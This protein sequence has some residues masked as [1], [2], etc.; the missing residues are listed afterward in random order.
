MK[1]AICS[2]ILIKNTIVKP[3]LFSILILI[4]NSALAQHQFGKITQDEMNMDQ[5]AFD[6]EADAVVIFDIGQSLFVN[7][8]GGLDIQFSRTRRVKIFNKDG[9][10]WGEVSIPFYMD[11][12]GK[13]E[14]V[15]SI[16]GFVY[17]VENNILVITELDPK[18][19][20]TEKVNDKWNRKKFAFP[21][22]KEGTI[23][24]YKYTMTTPFMFNLP[25]WEFQDKIPV[26]Y[27][28]YE[29]RMVPFYEYTFLLQ[30]ASKFSEQ[31]SFVSKG[32]ERVYAN[33]KFNDY[34]HQ[35]I[36]KNIPAFGDE[37]FITSVDD[38]IIKLD[39]QLANIHY[40]NGSSKSIITTWP[41]LANGLL[42]N[43]SFGKYVKQS[44]KHATK[45]I[46]PKMDLSGSSETEKAKKIILYVK[47]N[48]VWNDQYNHYTS[49]DVKKILIAQTGNSADINLYLTGILR[50]SGIN[51][52][53]VLISTRSHGKVNENYPFEHFFNS[54]VVLVETSEGSFLT[55]GT[56]KY[57]DF[58][59]ISSESVN[60]KGLVIREGS[61]N[62]VP[63]KPSGNSGVASEFIL[64]PTPGT[65]SVAFKWISST[66]GYDALV[67]RS[68]YNDD[69]SEL[70]SGLKG[71][72]K[73]VDNTMSTNYEL[74]DQPYSFSFTGNSASEVFGDNIMIH[75]FLNQTPIENPLKQKARKYPVDFIY[76]QSR[77]YKSTIIIPAGF[78][79]DSKPEN[80]EIDNGLFSLRI[81]SRKDN[82]KLI[83][84]AKYLFKKSIYKTSEYARLKAYFRYIVD[85]LNEYVVLVPE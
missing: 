48:M 34:I 37:S 79:I 54:V 22:V 19:I 30:G 69:L 43:G 11:G 27:S 13:S 7:T 71:T 80:F 32:I 15:E 65:S 44:E 75:P 62:W 24:E 76:P 18:S 64:T 23:I 33:V 67:Y 1:T 12:Y 53:P 2:F 9:F 73:D 4:S 60:G 66:T 78:K 8:N 6:P 52:A 21:N 84:E 50:G 16:K 72:I 14:R 17:N 57:L 49:D 51:A 58:D 63:L 74:L 47:Q 40:P 35:Y 5:C 38:Y 42:K 31:N 20:F 39:F 77:S 85:K 25:D 61:D 70:I 10:G 59:Q 83:V 41:E 28:S 45:S 46:L 29:A 82:S 68:R 3:V 26:I 56:S 55:D 36:M 81:H